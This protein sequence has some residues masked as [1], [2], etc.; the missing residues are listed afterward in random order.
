MSQMTKFFSNSGPGGY[1]QTLTGNT[2]GA[3]SPTGG[4]INIIGSGTVD[5]VGNPATSTLTISVSGAVATTYTEDV[6]TAAPAAGNLNVFGG[7]AGRDINTS[8]SGS[9]IHIDLDNAI[10][11]GD[12][13]NI[14]AGNNALSAVTG[15]INIGATNG[16]GNLKLVDTV[17]GGAAGVIKFGVLNFIHNYGGNTFVGNSAGNTATT[18]VIS[19]GIGDD[20][21]TSITS[22]TSNTALGHSTLAALTTGSSNTA[23]GTYA[24]TTS[25]GDSTNT[26]VGAVCVR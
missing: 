19:T 26:A 6:G 17:A 15:D 4:N 12:L 9:T 2:G 11:L 3:V 18:A 14:T 1:I 5:V 8:G 22:G 25:V 7:T 23:L 13:V 21:L 10:T 20:A 16:V 24:L